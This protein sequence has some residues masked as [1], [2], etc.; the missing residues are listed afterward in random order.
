MNHERIDDL[1]GWLRWAMAFINRVG[2]PIVAFA[3]MSYMCFFVLKE[4]TKAIESMKEVLI[5]MDGSLKQ[6]TRAL[7]HQRGIDD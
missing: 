7:R 6:Q 3:F 4:N 5:S 2:F 1:P